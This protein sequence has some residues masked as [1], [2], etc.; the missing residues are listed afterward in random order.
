MTNFLKTSTFRT[1]SDAVKA[2]LREARGQIRE[3]S[4]FCHRLRS[5]ASSHAE[6]NL[7]EKIIYDR[8]M[9][10]AAGNRP[11][12]LKQLRKW[13]IQARHYWKH[14]SPGALWLRA[15]KAEEAYRK[16]NLTEEVIE[17][18]E[19]LDDGHDE[20]RDPEAMQNEGQIG[21]A[22]ANAAG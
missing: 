5:A 2:V 12:F 7:A 16:T 4:A 20:I 17:H 6:R 14:E 1:R 10:I 21:N 9:E 8:K 19:M 13:E 15:K 18:A 11:V 22:R 3:F